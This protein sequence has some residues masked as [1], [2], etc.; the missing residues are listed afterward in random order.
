M[1]PEGMIP[2]RY[3]WIL[4]FNPMYYAVQLYRQAF[5]ISRFPEWR[6]LGAL[7]LSGIVMFVAGGLFF[8]YVK[9]G[10]ADVL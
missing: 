10:F 6:E 5:F 3:R 4:R 9:R 1:L 2:E 7:A 8:R